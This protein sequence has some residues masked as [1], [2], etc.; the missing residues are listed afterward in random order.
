M[1][2]KPRDPSTPPKPESFYIVVVDDDEGVRDVICECARHDGYRVTGVGTGKEALDL[3][4]SL[5][6]D[7]VL[8]D[9]MMTGMNGWQVLKA[10]KAHN[11]GI[12]VVVFTGYISEQGEDILLGR[13]ADAYLVKPIDRRRLSTLLRGLLFPNNLRRD[14]EVVA[15]DDD[16]S[17]LKA[18]EV[19]LGNRGL[20]VLP[21]TDPDEARQQIQEHLPDLL[22]C[23]LVLPG[24]NGL[25]FCQVLRQDPASASLPILIVTGHPSRDEVRRAI[26]LHVN[27]FLV[28]PFESVALAE[29]AV[30]V[31]RQSGRH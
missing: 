16:P 14:A 19:A 1:D 30:Q 17:I 2:Q 24:V 8:T 15:I 9:L 28:K 6:V 12:L 13:G 3:V 31:L 10:V 21:F 5:P 18:I 11:P 20:Y 26:D 25:D 22:I 27:G 4:K 23:D 29:K 7:L